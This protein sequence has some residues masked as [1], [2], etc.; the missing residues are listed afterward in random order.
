MSEM[1][2][3]TTRKISNLSFDSSNQLNRYIEVKFVDSVNRLIN[4]VTS[5]TDYAIKSFTDTIINVSR[6]EFSTLR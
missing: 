2:N 3:A 6:N 1:I 4:I 5:G